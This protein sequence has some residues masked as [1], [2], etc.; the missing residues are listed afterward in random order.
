MPHLE[1]PLQVTFQEPT[2]PEEPLIVRSQ[3]VR[4]RESGEIGSK[5]SV[6]VRK[7]RAYGLSAQAYGPCLL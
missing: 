3:I 6:Q 2:P 4:I 5:A 7:G 1:F